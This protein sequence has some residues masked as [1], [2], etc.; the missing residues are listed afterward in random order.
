MATNL[1]ENNGGGSF[2]FKGV[3]SWVSALLLLILAS[4]LVGLGIAL[5]IDFSLW[6]DLSDF[7][8]GLRYYPHELGL[9]VTMLTL[10]ALAVL[11]ILALLLFFTFG[12]RKARR[13]IESAVGRALGH[14]WVEVKLAALAVIYLPLSVT[15][16]RSLSWGWYEPTVLI[17]LLPYYVLGVY[18]G[19]NIVHSVTRLI[20]TCR[21]FATLEEKAMRRAIAFCAVPLF[22][23]GASVAL[24]GFLVWP[25]DSYLD[26]DYLFVLLLMILGTAATAGT[27]AWY[28][29]ETRRK[30]RELMALAAQINE[31][32][33]GNLDAVNRVPFTSELYHSAVQL[34]MIRTGIERAVDEGV[35]AERTK[36]EL[37]T[38]VS[39]D[40]KTPLTSVI[41]YTE[42]L[43]KEPGLS[44]QAKDYVN[45]LSVKAERLS[46]IVQDVFEVSKAATGNITL[47]MEELDLGRLLQ[48]TFAEMAET[49]EKTSLVWR[50]D[51]PDA[52]MPIYADG[53]RMYRVFQNLIR[54]CAQYSLEGSRVY[55]NLKAENGRAVA[56]LRNISKAELTVSGEDLVAR[57]VRGDQN[58]TTE[59]S[60][61]G[62]SIAQS[63]TEACSGRLS[64][65]TDGDLFTVT[66][67]FPLLP[68]QPQPEEGAEPQ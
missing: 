62:L 34:N 14:I 56:T 36:V 57:F 24:F 2:V 18:F 11:G 23:L 60:G 8:I 28:L 31:I 10:Y 43:K 55:V 59:G 51:I 3:L 35:R 61:L 41:S 1:K 19:H 5:L 6:R 58:R 29:R 13:A 53:Q 9:S 12:F 66:V 64:V 17:L 44:E 52:P 67:D 33:G 68:A 48:Q 21:S 42:L 26:S 37:I 4:A 47:N 65:S 32:Y 50:I 15:I 45:I 25:M 63:F 22:F 46:Q 40:I 39:H 16:F 49:L 20:A 38:N 54:N 7:I 27:A 30:E